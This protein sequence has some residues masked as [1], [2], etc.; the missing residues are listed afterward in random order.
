MVAV[1]LLACV[2]KPARTEP[3]PTGAEPPPVD[4]PAD[5]VVSGDSGPP[6]TPDSAP[7]TDTGPQP[8]DPLLVD[9]TGRVYALDLATASWVAPVGVGPLIGGSLAG[10]QL[11]VSP[12]AFG[13]AEVDLLAALAEGNQQD[14]CSASASLAGAV[15]SDPSFT[16]TA[17]ALA[18]AFAGVPVDVADVELAGSFL[19]DGGR[20]GGG[21]LSGSLDTRTLGVV[22]GLGDAEDAVCVLLATFGV[23]C[24]ACADAALY[25]VDVAAVD[26]GGPWLPYG[27][28]QERT[29]YDIANDPACH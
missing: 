10:N 19:P 12:T 22:F 6:P 5:P 16:A 11:L 17:A 27:T 1:A 13:A 23:S 15:W 18:L 14:P 26:L 7:A 20:I 21:E 8:G 2:A 25:C 29:A 9:V 3:T 4:T 28:V 24:T